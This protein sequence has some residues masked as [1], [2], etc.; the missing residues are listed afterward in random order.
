MIH[1]FS[2]HSQKRASLIKSPPLKEKPAVSVSFLR[3]E[4]AQPGRD[5]HQGEHQ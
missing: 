4:Q 5:V 3:L 2:F 1:A